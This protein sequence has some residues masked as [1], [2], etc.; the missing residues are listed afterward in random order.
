VFQSKYSVLVSALRD[1]ILAALIPAS[2][3]IFIATL[4][5]LPNLLNP[6]DIWIVAESYIGLAFLDVYYLARKYKV[7]RKVIVYFVGL[8]GIVLIILFYVPYN[9]Q[10]L[11]YVVTAISSIILYIRVIIEFYRRKYA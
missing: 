4:L 3:M 11:A 7:S 8:T 1:F 6:F 9:V 2:F 5:L 10:I